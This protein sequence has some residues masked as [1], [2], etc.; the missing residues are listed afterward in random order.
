[1]ITGCR[2]VTNIEIQ[3]RK[4]HPTQEVPMALLLLADPSPAQ[5]ASYVDEG[6]VFL[7]QSRDQVIGVFVILQT[8]PRTLEIMNVTIEPEWQGRGIGKRLIKAAIEEARVRGARRLT[9]RTQS[10]RTASVART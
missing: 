5:V 6:E 8:G 7:A 9:T 3:I 10:G 2:R 4:R 1:V